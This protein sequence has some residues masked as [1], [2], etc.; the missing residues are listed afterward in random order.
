MK[1]RILF[2][3]GIGISLGLLAWTLWG[4]H[5][6]EVARMARGLRGGWLLAGALF[7]FVA[8]ALRAWRWGDLLAGVQ[9]VRFPDRFVALTI[10]YMGNN[11]YPARAGELLRAYVL[12]RRT[13]LSVS[14]ALATIVIER[15]FDGL[16]VALLA[17]G[18]LLF[19]PLPPALY[20]LVLGGALAFGGALLLLMAAAAGA[21]WLRQGLDRLG[22]RG[23]GPVG[24]RL[25]GIAGRFLEGL[26]ALRRPSR[27]VR[28]G[29]VT[30]LI[31]LAEA[32]TYA[33]VLQA[34]P[35]RSSFLALLVMV[36]AANLATALPAAPG[37]LGTFEAPGVMVLRAFGLPSAVA[38]A[39][40]LLLHLIL[41]FPITLLGLLLSLREGLRG[42]VPAVGAEEGA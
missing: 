34:F 13:G 6:G 19:V 31:W 26:M 33:L 40:T 38:I 4:L 9:P 22:G 12:R 10:G 1:Q 28:V 14:A 11:L 18:A 37:Y 3:A 8:V 25:A 35:V 42:P 29:L 7:Y 2:G 27:A 5:W 20:P 15:V 39:Y 30:A 23:A 21:P 16:M 17:L 36:A 24:A 41:W 32:A